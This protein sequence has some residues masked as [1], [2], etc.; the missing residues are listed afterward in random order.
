MNGLR[1]GYY[2]VSIINDDL[3]SLRA[4]FTTVSIEQCCALDLRTDDEL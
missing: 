3:A 4:V 2:R 1:R